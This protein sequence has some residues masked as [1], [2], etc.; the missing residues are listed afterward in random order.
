MRS[1]L[2]FLLSLLSVASFQGS[3]QPALEQ[4]VAEQRVLEW[5]LPEALGF[6]VP[7]LRRLAPALATGTRIRAIGS[8]DRWVVAIPAA[9][10]RFTVHRT[11][12]IGEAIPAGDLAPDL[13]KLGEVVQVVIKEDDAIFVGQT[14]YMQVFRLQLPA[15]GGHV[16]V[17]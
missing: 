14:G 10:A 2:C 6:Q 16:L 9:G 15:N 17:G 12:A 4:Q 5:N 1:V 7:A 11:E 13:T 8:N 3:A